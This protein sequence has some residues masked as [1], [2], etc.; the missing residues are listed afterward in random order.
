MRAQV[1]LLLLACVLR[2]AWAGFAADCATLASM[3][4][5]QLDAL[6]AS[7]SSIVSLPVEGACYAGCIL[8]GHGSALMAPA[9]QLSFWSGKCFKAKGAVVNFANPAVPNLTPTVRHRECEQ[10]GGVAFS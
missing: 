8:P 6:Y 5:A 3:S 2:P 7:A 9:M 1:L 4:D 10:E